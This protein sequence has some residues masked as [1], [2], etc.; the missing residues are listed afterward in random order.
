[1]ATIA[2]PL[3]IALAGALVY[4]FSSAKPSELGR[5]AFFC[6]LFWLTYQLGSRTF[7]F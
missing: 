5:I 1:M 6:G 3:L 2:A 7:H 4:A